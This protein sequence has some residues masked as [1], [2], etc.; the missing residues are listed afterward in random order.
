MELQQAI[1]GFLLFKKGEGL[2]PRTIKTYS[3]HLRYFKEHQQNKV[4]ETVTSIDVLQFL[5]YMRTEHKPKRWG[6]DDKPLSSQTIR[7]IW[8]ALR[9]FYSWAEEVLDVPNVMSKVPAPKASNEERAPFS[10]DE[11]RRLLKATEPMRA[12]KPRSGY[13]YLQQ[14]RDTA[15]K[16]G[17]AHV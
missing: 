9:S 11:I 4:L 7:N 16:I 1:S 10:K 8:V 12:Q 14:L 17:R 15:I 6:D 3:I 13:Q 5:E 2:S